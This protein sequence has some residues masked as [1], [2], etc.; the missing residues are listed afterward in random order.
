MWMIKVIIQPL[1]E[2]RLVHRVCGEGF[3]LGFIG[4]TPAACGVILA[5]IQYTEVTIWALSLLRVTTS[6]VLCRL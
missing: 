3:G 6:F 5:G 2:D 1:V 4:G